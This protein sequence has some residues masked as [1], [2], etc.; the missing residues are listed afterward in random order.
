MTQFLTYL[1]KGASA[2]SVT[3][4]GSPSENS[5]LLSTHSDGS[6]T[7]AVPKTAPN[8]YKCIFSKPN[9]AGGIYCSFM[10]GLLVATFN[11]TVPL[12]VREVFQWGG[13]QSGLMFGAL[14]APR[15]A[16]TP[17]VGW[18]KDRVGTRIPTAFG[19]AIL[20][21]LLW[22]LG[23]PGSEQFPFMNQENRGPV[24]YVL[25]MTLI[26]LQFSFLN[27]AGSIE[28]TGKLLIMYLMSKTTPIG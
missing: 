19:F 12:H 18:L 11:A 28:A 14:Q 16:V 17:L 23:I 3:E 6:E 7:Y 1:L 15:L 4:R 25:A 20:A 2:D 21:P 5:P 9:F 10:F 24:L 8:F 13:M 27:G 22:L 26:G